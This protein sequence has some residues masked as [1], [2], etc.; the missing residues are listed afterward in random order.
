MTLPFE[1]ES[2]CCILAHQNV[3]IAR[4]SRTKRD[5]EAKKCESIITLEKKFGVRVCSSLRR[6]CFASVGKE[7]V[8]CDE[9]ESRNRNVRSIES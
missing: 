4:I 2:S 3:R 6:Q 1:G 8:P 7:V 5:S 9:V